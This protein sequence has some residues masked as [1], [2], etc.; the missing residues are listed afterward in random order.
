MAIIRSGVPVVVFDRNIKT[1]TAVSYSPDSG[2]RRLPTG[3]CEEFT[4]VTMPP[5]MVMMRRNEEGMVVLHPVMR[6][7]RGPQRMIP[8]S[9]KEDT[10]QRSRGEISESEE[11]DDKYNEEDCSSCGSV[12]PYNEG[13]SEDES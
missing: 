3:E 7:Y 1:I 11:K 10:E 2:M 12:G 4:Q 5:N 6:W 9:T 8:E 13:G